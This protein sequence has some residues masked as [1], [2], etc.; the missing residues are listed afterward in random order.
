MPSVKP[1]AC[2][3]RLALACGSRLC[4]PAA[5]AARRLRTGYVRVLVFC[6]SC[7]RQAAA[8]LQALVD[9]GRGD[10]PLTALRF[11][12]SQCHTDRTDFVMTSL[13]GRAELLQPGVRRRGGELAID[14]NQSA[15][16]WDVPEV[17]MLDARYLRDRA[18]RFRD[19][20]QRTHNP[21]DA[22]YLLELATDADLQ[23]EALA[24]AADTEHRPPRGR[25]NGPRGDVPPS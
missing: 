15:G 25:P 12:C 4:A 10:V 2:C 21:D 19:L 7:R 17:R 6:N 22:R 5:Y 3:Y 13:C 8:D 18:I 1:L 20:A 14:P 9:A 16:A 23:A 11:R 24:P